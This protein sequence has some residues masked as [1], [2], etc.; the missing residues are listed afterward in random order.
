MHEMSLVTSL[1]E[2]LEN[3]AR[4]QP[5][6]RV[7]TLFLSIGQLSCIDKDT[8][9]WCINST[10][11]GTLLDGANIVT[12][13]EEALAY[14]DHCQQRY[15]PDNLITPCPH[16]GQQQQRILQGRDLRISAIDVIPIS[17]SER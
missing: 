8:L 9:L 10:A 1:H 2:T 12:S 13:E 17:E 5:F 11:P 4:T 16:C 15:I 7:K 3:A 6:L 14:C